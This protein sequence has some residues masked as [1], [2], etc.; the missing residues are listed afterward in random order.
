MTKGNA[1]ST[2][3]EKQQDLREGLYYEQ[4]KTGNKGK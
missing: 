4:E 3:N 2:N 1:Y